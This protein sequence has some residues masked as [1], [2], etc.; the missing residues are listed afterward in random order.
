M[1]KFIRFVVWTAIFVGLVVAIARLTAIRWWRVPIDDPWLRASVEP[2]LSG[3]DLI[4]L[5][6][7]TAPQ[8]GDLVV[9]ADPDSPDRSVVARLVG[10]GRDKIRF[11]KGRLSL[12]GR[13]AQS[14]RECL[15]AVFEVSDPEKETPVE[16]ECV[17]EDLQG[18]LHERGE[19]G[20]H[21]F[22]DSTEE[23]GVPLGEVYLVSDNRLFP[24]DSRDFGTV[25]RASCKE[26]VF[27][28]LWGLTG[29]KD[30]RRRLT[31]IR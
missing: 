10:E 15:P 31:Y 27:F 28:R 21:A 14:E 2:T 26:S 4:L 23:A 6:R 12:N 17:M 24:Y 29:W 18:V 22:R 30:A 5:W 20:S 25:S 1:G 8:F 19:I 16:Q 11:E 7:L 13:V 9:C 3:G